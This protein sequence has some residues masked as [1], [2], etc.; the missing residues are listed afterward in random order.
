[1][2]I[3][4]ILK[5]PDNLV[6]V[7]PVYSSFADGSQIIQVHDRDKKYIGSFHGIVISVGPRNGLGIKSGDKVL[8]RRHEG[9]P[10]EHEGKEYLS[11]KSK[12]IEAVL[13]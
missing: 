10:I 5:A 7:E 8:F 2:S 9:T 13:N 6:I 3:P 4:E 1:M 11:L 12:W